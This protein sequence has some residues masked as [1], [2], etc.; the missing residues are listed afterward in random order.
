MNDEEWVRTK[1]EMHNF[2]QML[3][4]S[5]AQKTNLTRSVQADQDTDMASP[6]DDATQRFRRSKTQ[7]AGDERDAAAEAAAESDLSKLAD[8][9]GR[10]CD[11]A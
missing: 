9:F 7:R 10:L 3:E 2:G 8:C 11:K 5:M 4:R 1:A 6:A